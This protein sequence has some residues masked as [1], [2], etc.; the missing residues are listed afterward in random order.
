MAQ[1]DPRIPADRLGGEGSRPLRVLQVTPRYFPYMGGVESHVYQV[2]RRMARAGVQVTVLTTDPSGKLPAREQI[3]SVQVRRVRAWPADRDYYFAPGIYRVIRDGDWDLVHVQGYHTLVPP[4]AMLAAWKAHIPYLLTF[5]GGGHS[6]AWR[7]AA[8]GAQR[9]L[10]RPLLARA[11]CLVAVAEFE[12][13]V[14]SAELRLPKSRFRLIPNGADLPAVPA[15]LPGRLSDSPRIAS[16]G[17]LERYKG[18][19]RILKALPHIL[20]QEPDTRLWIAGSGPFEAPLRRLAADLGVADRVEIRA[21]PADN[22][23]AMAQELST[24]GLAVLLSEYETQPI[25]ILEAL[26]LGRPALVADTSGLS[27]LAERGLARAIPLDSPPE[28]V[29]AAAVEQLRHPLP[30]KPLRW[31]TWDDCADNLLALYRSVAPPPGVAR[32]CR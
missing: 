10:L 31:P 27:E 1:S 29:A 26:A 12:V 14:Y 3:E 16:L 4:L 19:H 18:H 28:L 6:S 2:S 24:V 20:R 15:R 5:H 11:E 17:R 23:S 9:A 32:C 22:R 13:R 7:H 8:R 21:V 30:V 25:A